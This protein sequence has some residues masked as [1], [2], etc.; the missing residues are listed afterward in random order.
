MKTIYFLN[1]PEAD[2]FL[3]KAT[4]VAPEPLIIWTLRIDSGII[5]LPALTDLVQKYFFFN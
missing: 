3:V 2:R 4:N 5:S 1:E